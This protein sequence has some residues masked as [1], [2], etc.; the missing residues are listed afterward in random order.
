VNRGLLKNFCVVAESQSCTCAK[1]GCGGLRDI[2][3]DCP[4]HGIDGQLKPLA[5]TH[6]HPIQASP[7]GT[8]AG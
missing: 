5:K 8:L 1:L 7:V 3:T 2:R 6:L 4:E